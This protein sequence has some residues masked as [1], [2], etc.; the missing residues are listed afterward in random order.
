[1]IRL[2]L[3]AA[4]MA[5]SIAGSLAHAKMAI[6]T[7]AVLADAGP[8]YVYPAPDGTVWFTAQSAGKLGRLDPRTG[9]SDLIALGPDAALHGVI[10]GPDGA[11]WVTEGGQNA[12]ARVDQVT[13][14]VKLFPLPKEFADA[15]LNTLTFDKSGIIWFT[16]QSGVYGR[17]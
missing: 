8:H 11:A 3:M 13:R 17:V 10:V 16:G 5:M 2:G 14:E 4:A 15:N 6:Q 7:F 1:M 9:K 12:I